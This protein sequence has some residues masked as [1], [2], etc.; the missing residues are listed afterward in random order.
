MRV[1]W[2]L[3]LISHSK[4]FIYLKTRKTGGTSVEIYFE[5]Y[6]LDPGTP[7]EE[8]H[9]RA[10][11]VS[12]WGVIGSRGHTDETWF[13]HMHAS[14]VRELLGERIWGE[15]FK[16]C[17]VRNPFDKVVSQFWYELSPSLR[18]RM[19]H[20]D[21]AMVRE[22]FAEW[23]KLLRFPADQWIYTI[24]GVAVVDRF[25]SYEKLSEQMAE[26]CG[27]L[28]ISWHPQHLGAYKREHRARS[29][30]YFSYHTSK[31]IDRVR[32]KYAWEL[33][34]FGYSCN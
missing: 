24:D 34:F 13:N 15:Y 31:T 27:H 11:A 6:C 33:E 32:A 20:A 10:A 21:F 22:A 17:V 1:R 16:F 12:E 28:D 30:P 4:R 29:E 2:R 19:R 9:H 5:R 23:T 26:V 18:E 7:Y 14:R 25:I 3:M 8:R